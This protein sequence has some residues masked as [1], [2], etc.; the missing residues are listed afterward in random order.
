MRRRRI[1]E[2]SDHIVVANALR[3]AGLV[4]EHPA[5]GEA[6]SERAAV[7]LKMMGVLPGSSDFRI[8]TVPPRYPW[9]RGVALELKARD[10]DFS[11]VSADQRKFL[12]NLWEIGWIVGWGRWPHVIVWL[13]WLGYDV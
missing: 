13:R 1:S 2:D 4:W 10:K 7:K 11:D 3:R 9:A 8:Y 12:L 5:N 6:R